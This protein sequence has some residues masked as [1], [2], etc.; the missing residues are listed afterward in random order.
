MSYIDARGAQ[1]DFDITASAGIK[2][3]GAVTAGGLARDLS[4]ATLTVVVKDDREAMNINYGGTAYGSET[5]YPQTITNAASGLFTFYIPPAEFTNKE[6]GRL[7]YE[8]YITEDGYKTGL[9]WGYINV[10][11]RG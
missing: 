10:L 7:T 8:L 9:M 3:S 2:R 11:E 6:G 4:N 1:V 5:S